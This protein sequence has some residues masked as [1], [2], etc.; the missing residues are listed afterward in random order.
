MPA[1]DYNRVLLKTDEGQSD[2]GDPD[3]DEETASDEDNEDSAKYINASLMSV[4]P[5]AVQRPAL[6]SDRRSRAAAAALSSNKKRR[7]RSCANFRNTSN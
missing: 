2:E 7:R 6:V 1:D 4:R 5:F 3:G